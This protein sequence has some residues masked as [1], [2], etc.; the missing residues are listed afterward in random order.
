MQ[1]VVETAIYVCEVVNKQTHQ[2]SWIVNA[3]R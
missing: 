3:L 1:V 2:D